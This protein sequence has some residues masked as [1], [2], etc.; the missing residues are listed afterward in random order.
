[1]EKLEQ[2]IQLIYKKHI[3][4]SPT[5]DYDYNTLDIIRGSI[6]KIK[7]QQENPNDWYDDHRFEQYFDVKKSLNELLN[8]GY[9]G[10]AVRTGGNSGGSCW[11]GEASYEPESDVNLQNEYLDKVLEVIAPDVTY[12]TYRKIEKNLIHKTEYVK[13]EYYGNDDRYYVE[14]VVVKDL[15]QILKE[16]NTLIDNDKI[17]QLIAD[18]SNTSS[19]K[20]LKN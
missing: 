4:D 9:I 12:L 2:L 11:G 17:D 6:A 14:L 8:S 7:F 13:R 19:Q 5:Y 20:K 16:K 18:F 3:E 15:V 10:F 1:M